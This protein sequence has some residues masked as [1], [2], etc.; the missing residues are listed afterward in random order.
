MSAAPLAVVTDASVW[1]SL[2]VQQ[3]LYH[4]PSRRWL[5]AYSFAGS[6]TIAPII[7]LAEV[8]GAIARRT[9]DS[10][11][12]W[13]S[14]QV[15]LRVPGLRVVTISRRLGLLAATIAA[16]ERLRGADTLYVAVAQHLCI[17][18]VSWDQEQIA[19]SGGAI[20]TYTPRDLL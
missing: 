14:V 8:A 19:R 4:K 2:F 3:D 12:A 13:Q 6:A 11:L 18:L 15:V 9:A 20:A 7:L 5:H 10:I 16:N 1:V 17:P